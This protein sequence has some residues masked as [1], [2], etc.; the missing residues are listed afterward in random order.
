[1]VLMSCCNHDCNQGSDC[2][3]RVAKVGRRIHAAEPLP[4]STW[5]HY[6]KDLARAF[7]FTA[8]VMTLTGFAAG[9]I[10]GFY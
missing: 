5:R 8:A 7:L 9:L 4:P 10:C 6:L 3:A 1:V 2:P